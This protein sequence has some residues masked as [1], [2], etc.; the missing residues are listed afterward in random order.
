[1]LAALQR[2]LPALA[3]V[4]MIPDVTAD[5]RA[6]LRRH[7]LRSGDAIQLASCLYLERELG[8]PVA[9]VAYDQRLVDAARAEGLTVVTTS[10]GRRQKI[11]TATRLRTGD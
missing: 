2:D 1:M 7:A 9:F 5:S 6:L 10:D 4:E 3:V 11:R 8:G